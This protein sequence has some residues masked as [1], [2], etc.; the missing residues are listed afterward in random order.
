[1]FKDASYWVYQVQ[2]SSTID[3][4]WQVS[5]EDILH[6]G[7]GYKYSYTHHD[8][9]VNYSR[10]PPGSSN[11]SKKNFTIYSYIYSDPKTSFG[12]YYSVEILLKNPQWG[13][14]SVLGYPF[15]SRSVNKGANDKDSFI[16]ELSVSGQ[17]YKSVIRVRGFSRPY[18]Q[19]VNY[20]Y[21]PKFGLVRTDELTSGKI[22]ELV[23]YKVD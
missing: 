11:S 17:T 2:G 5:H 3:S 13:I 12:D 4:V 9:V 1:M 19:Y 18:G 7:G 14:E 8:I 22:W 23:R 21:A 15:G 20:Y 6:M 10:K 16:K